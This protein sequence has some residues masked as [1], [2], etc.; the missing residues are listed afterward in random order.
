MNEWTLK[1][2]NDPSWRPYCLKCSTMKRMEDRPYGYESSKCK[3]KINFNL[4]TI[5]GEPYGT[6][7]DLGH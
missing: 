1:K 3:L 5:H 7:S 6:D 2:K 4:D